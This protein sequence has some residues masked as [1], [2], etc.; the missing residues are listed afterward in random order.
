M[1]PMRLRGSSLA[2]LL[3]ALTSF[4]TGCAAPTGGDEAESAGQ[5]ITSAQAITDV[6]AS[7][8]FLGRPGAALSGD[9]GSVLYVARCPSSGPGKILRV[10]PKANTT[11]EIGTFA[12]GPGTTIY[13]QDYGADFALWRVMKEKASPTGPRIERQIGLWDAALAAPVSVDPNPLFPRN[14]EDPRAEWVDFLAYAGQGRVV[15]SWEWSY[16]SRQLGVV[17]LASGQPVWTAPARIYSK[18]SSVRASS[19]RKT[20][21][22]STDRGP[23]AL[24]VGA[25]VTVRAL[26]QALSAETLPY[27]VT[28]NYPEIDPGR[29]LYQLASASGRWAWSSVNVKTGVRTDLGTALEYSGVMSPGRT[30]AFANDGTPAALVLGPNGVGVELRVVRPDGS[31]VASAVP[32]GA[33]RVRYVA[34]KGAFV[35][36]EEIVRVPG[37]QAGEKVDH[38][39]LW[40]V[41]PGAN[42]PAAALLGGVE[43]AP[44]TSGTPVPQ[45]HAGGVNLFAWKYDRT[46]SL[47]GIDAQGAA[48]RELVLPGTYLHTLQGQRILSDDCVVD[49]AGA[50]PAPVA[51]GCIEGATPPR[52]APWVPLSGARVFVLHDGASSRQTAKIFRY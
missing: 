28:G 11:V 43:V 24:D 22:V 23:Y 47:V 49:L 21:L 39:K 45:E 4:A 7:S 8:A 5:D 15:A 26:D 44:Y 40:L 50:A 12:A 35:V 31:V 34:P 1:S 41:R 27:D 51:N 32:D 13:F 18:R 16:Q 9:A 14:Y 36:V 37:A 10:D 2:P 17:S 6:C 30:A 33:K 25:N 19:D 42:Q 48:T 52:R 29:V 20:F 46:W 38:A 3:L